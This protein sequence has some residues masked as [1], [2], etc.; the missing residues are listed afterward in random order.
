MDNHEILKQAPLF[1]SLSPRFLKGLGDSATRRTYKEGELIVR[2]GNPGVG[3]FV[4]TKGK[5]QVV[6]TN[7]SGRRYELG[8]HG[9]GEVIGEMAV[10]DGAVRSADIV[11]LE[12][13]ECL[14]LASWTF[15][16]F[17]E[18]HPQVALE[19]LP[20][21]VKRFRETHEAL[22]KAQEKPGAQP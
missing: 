6:K 13:T 17:M 3:L 19:I 10:L 4:I 20:M 16:S 18:S 22:M 7:E 21:V 15:N 12:E 2:Q 8:T 14:V 1:S 9:P 11:A 5:V